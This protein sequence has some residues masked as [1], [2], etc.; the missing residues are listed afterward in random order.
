MTAIKPT[1]MNILTELNKIPGGYNYAGA[2]G[3]QICFPLRAGGELRF[4][5]Y[6]DDPPGTLGIDLYDGALPPGISG[7]VTETG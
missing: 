1:I 5:I 4:G 6:D 2:A 3:V 7:P